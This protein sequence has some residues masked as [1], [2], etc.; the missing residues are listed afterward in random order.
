MRLSNL[1][2]GGTTVNYWGSK[3]GGVG[4]ITKVC[5]LEVWWDSER[6]WASIISWIVL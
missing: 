2:K 3:E 1:E 5:G 6:S 4:D